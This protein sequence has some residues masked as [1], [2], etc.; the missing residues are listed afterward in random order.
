ML[1]TRI[2][3]SMCRLSEMDSGVKIMPTNHVTKSVEMKWRVKIPW[4][5]GIRGR[6]LY[7]LAL[8]TSAPH[9]LADFSATSSATAA[10]P[11]R[12]IQTTNQQSYQQP[13]RVCVEPKPKFPATEGLTKSSP[14][15]G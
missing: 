1:V 9:A 8:F 6:P 15:R 5:C 7:G 12:S 11:G 14:K 2:S 10:L 3:T 4:R 13:I